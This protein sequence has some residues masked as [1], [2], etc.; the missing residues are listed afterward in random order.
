M[1]WGL[2][3]AEELNGTEPRPEWKG[4]AEL[5]KGMSPLAIYYQERGGE[6]VPNGLEVLCIEAS[7]KPK[8][9]DVRKV[10]SDRLGKS[11]TPV[12][13]IVGYQAGGEKRAAICGAAGGNPPVLDSAEL[14]QA[15]QIAIAAMDNPDQHSA[16]GTLRDLLPQLDPPFEWMKRGPLGL[17]NTGLFATQELLAGVPNRSDWNEAV[18]S[19]GPLKTLRGHELIERLG[20]HIESSQNH[21]SRLTRAGET[22]AVALFCNE[23]EPFDAP[24]SRLNGFSPVS[25]ALAEA[26]R[27]PE[28]RIDWVI[29]TRRSE[30]RLYSARSDIGVGQRG[31]GETFV[32]LNLVVL[33]FDSAGYLQTLFSAEALASEGSVDEALEASER[34]AA[35]LAHRLRERVYNETVPALAQAVATRLQK[36]RRTNDLSRTDLASAYE[37][38]MFILFRLLFVA[39]A[40]ATGLL[41]YKTNESYKDASLTKAVRGIF[42]RLH[43]SGNDSDREAEAGDGCFSKDSQKLWDGILVLWDAINEGNPELGVP[44]YNGGLFSNK[45]DDSAIGAEVGK[46]SK[47]S[48]A[49]IGPALAAMF[50][51][52]SPEGVGPVDFRALSVREFGTIYE[53]LIESR[54]ATNEA[55]EF[56]LLNRSGEKKASGTYFT[57]PFAVEHLL[58]ESLE[59]ALDRHIEEL[60]LLK[61][62]DADLKEKFFDFKCADIAMG[63]GHFL[64]AALDRIEARLSGFLV[65]NPIPEIISELERL[66]SASEKSLGYAE[67]IE[68]S[69]LLRRQVARHCVY[70]VDINQIAVELAR[71]SVWIHTF[72]PGLPLSFLDHNFAC[73]D[74]L[75]GV[76][77][78][79]EA[80]A[81]YGESEDNLFADEVPKFLKRAEDSLQTLAHTA[82]ATK[83]EIETARKAD[84]QAQE[85]VR[86]ARALFDL[87]T[88]KHD[89]NCDTA[90]LE[91]FSEKTINAEAGKKSIKESIDNLQPLHFPTTFPEVFIRENPGFDIVIGNPPWEKVKVETDTWWCLYIPGLK[92]R[93]S[94]RAQR[95]AKLKRTKPYLEEQFEA[96]KSSAKHYRGFLNSAF[97]RSGRGDTDLYKAFSWRMLELTRDYGHIGVVLPRTIIQGAGS[98]NWRREVLDQGSFSSVV[99]LQNKGEWVFGDVDERYSI[100]LIAVTKTL[101]PDRQIRFSATLKSR[102]ELEACQL[103]EVPVEEFLTWSANLI[104]PSIPQ[105]PAALKLFLKLRNHP[106]LDGQ[107]PE[108]TLDG[109]ARHGTA[110]HGTGQGSMPNCTQRATLTCSTL[111]RT[112]CNQRRAPVSSS[113][114]SFRS[115][116]RDLACLHW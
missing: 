28:N 88:A 42:E 66:R 19:S 35:D 106:R 94:E 49:E 33:P 114:W 95:I 17:N 97:P 101:E 79:K 9:T 99:V 75:T 82:D 113:P 44:V 24:S 103:H 98:E 46:L 27:D 77:M 7:S 23:D 11:A 83:T 81:I 14:A 16:T 96:D 22:L 45:I 65:D 30:I 85:D 50:I 64:V 1:N 55:G 43:G 109:T 41:P 111:S 3:L 100:A 18:K 112:R 116:K 107:T 56:E 29:L 13:V 105:H 6:L 76:G 69:S 108:P 86:S 52:E 8:V 38:V 72:V 92:S 34:F 60:E 61:G 74:S 54:L 71:L 20:F 110:R 59:P 93:N 31:R 91:N 70:G 87:V 90:R 2:E 78:L 36:R 102:D 37:Q 40:E 115:D 39:Y 32:E 26:G 80:S 53:G 62:N 57:K 67:D 5:P 4:S 10:W 21:V 104:F 73:G 58:N 63:S 25:R 84:L 15:K 12:L 47:L 51:D 48:D 89:P 68:T